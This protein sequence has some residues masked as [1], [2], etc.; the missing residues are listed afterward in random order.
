MR[1]YHLAEAEGGG[2]TTLYYGALAEALKIA[3]DQTDEMQEGLFLQTESDV[4]GYLEFIEA[5]HFRG[6]D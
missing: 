6:H 5:P 2:A 3:A 1:L 4:V